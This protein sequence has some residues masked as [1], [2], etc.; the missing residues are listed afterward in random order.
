MRVV[1]SIILMM[2]A[3][4]NATLARS[5]TTQWTATL[6]TPVTKLRSIVADDRQWR[7]T[8][9][10]C[11]GITAGNWQSHVRACKDISERLGLVMTFTSGDKMLT[12]EQ[13]AKCNKRA[14]RFKSQS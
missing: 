12:E 3:M 7:C 5:D 6:A 9:G 2:F 4:P 10:S 14:R 11:K 1:P 13:L 8:E